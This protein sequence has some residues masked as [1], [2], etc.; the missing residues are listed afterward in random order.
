[1]TAAQNA[2]ILGEFVTG[3]DQFNSDDRPQTFADLTLTQE[4]PLLS[5]ISMIAPS[6]DWFSG[7]Y[8][9]RPVD[10]SS[11][12]W[13]ESF[14]IT[15]FPFDSGTESGDTY[16]I[17]NP[18]QDP[19]VPISQLTADT[20]PS[21]GILLDP[22]QQQ[23][24]PVAMWSC[25]LQL[26]VDESTVSPT[27]A[28]STKVQCVDLFQACDVNTDCC[29]GSC[30]SSKCRVSNS[31]RAERNRFRISAQGTGGGLGGFIGGA[32]GRDRSSGGGLLRGRA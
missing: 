32:A 21:N 16:S 28:P 23:V 14:S 6:P 19:I 24:L 17:S 10:M 13:L 20:V 15:T 1:M 26:T 8:N 30:R 25:S 12:V 9:Y 31:N 5:S 18:S 4:F 22:T 29:S 27:S 3:R 11:E 7:L 2:G